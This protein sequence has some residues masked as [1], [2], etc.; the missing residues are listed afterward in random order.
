MKKRRVLI[1]YTGGTI[2]MVRNHLTGGLVAFDFNHLFEQIPELHRLDVEL[3]SISFEQPIDSS[4]VTPA[5]W[6]TLASLI[7]EK[8]NHFDGFVILHG[9]DTMAYTASALSFMLQGLKK[10]VI[11]TGSQLPIGTIRTDGKENFITSIEIAAMHDDFGESIVQEVAIYFEYSLYRGN[12]TSK[13]SASEFEA[14]KSGNYPELARVGVDINVNHS[15]LYRSKLSELQVRTEMDSSVA[16]IWLYPGIK[17]EFYENL[18]DVKR[19]KGIVL[20]TFGSGNGPNHP[21]MIE[22]IGRFIIDG[23]LVLNITQCYSGAVQLGKYDSSKQFLNV[24]V[25]GG[26]TLTTEA[27]ITKMMFVLANYKNDTRIRE[28]LTTSLCGEM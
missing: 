21:L 3:E 27:A 16:H 20:S 14:F 8:Y 24:G 15:V 4:E 17:F 25:L 6:G 26:G 23:G 5:I 1:I 10:P 28:L 2:G 12:R 13:V 11:L 18:F 7:Q 9:T 22:M 19:V